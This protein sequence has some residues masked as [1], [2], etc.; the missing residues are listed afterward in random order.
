M[1]FSILLITLSS[2]PLRLGQIASLL[3]KS[4][5]FRHARV[6]QTMSQKLDRI[7]PTNISAEMFLHT[8]TESWERAQSSPFCCLCK[9][10]TQRRAEEM[11]WEETVAFAWRNP[12]LLFLWDG[13]HPPQRREGF[14]H[15]PQNVSPS[16]VPSSQ[17]GTRRSVRWA[18][19]GQG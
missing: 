2:S 13:G 17:T 4:N 15:P 14:N 6:W 3:I 7:F 19:K 8:K 18:H 5:L 10:S 9:D 1:P 16:P 11:V 12:S